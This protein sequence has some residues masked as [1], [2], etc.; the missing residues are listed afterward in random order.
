MMGVRAEAQVGW[1]GGILVSCWVDFGKVSWSEERGILRRV[2]LGSVMENGSFGVISGVE[3][4]RNGGMK[5]WRFWV[6][7]GDEMGEVC[8][9]LEA[10][11]GWNQRGGRGLDF[12]EEGREN[13]VLSGAL[14]VLSL[15]RRQKA[16]KE[17]WSGGFNGG[18]MLRDALRDF[19]FPLAQ[20]TAAEVKGGGRR[21]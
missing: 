2:E 6:D 14:D 16:A 1:K 21:G 5:C 20:A 17:E 8:W 3:R 10:L 11:F 4:M 13:W 19:E 12:A 15:S 9:V 7:L 18:S